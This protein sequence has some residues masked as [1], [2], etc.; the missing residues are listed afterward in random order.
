[1]APTDQIR[2]DRLGPAALTDAL[3]LSEEAGWNQTEADWRIFFEQ[4]VVFGVPGAAGPLA[5]GAVL[6]FGGFGWV[7]MVL[8]TGAAR[9]QGLGTA[10][11]KRCVAELSSMRCLSVL[12]A[13]PQGEQIYR[14]LGFL[15][16]FGLWRL[17]G[18][19]GGGEPVAG[20]RRAALA[21]LDTIVAL[22]ARAF[23][24]PR[25]RL[26]AGLLQRAPEAAVMLKDGSGF[27]L[28]RPGRR[29]LQIGPLVAADEAAALSLL[30]AALAQQSGPVIIDVPD[31]WAALGSHLEA[32]GFARERPFLRMALGRSEPFGDPGRLFA[33]AGPELG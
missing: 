24:A 8:V 11:L 29:A 19:G 1:M 18:E 26:L 16:Q 2:I 32:R 12:D 20:V 13:T 10:I 33:A 23:G 21:D 17:R 6:P 14:P 15:P 25:R 22:D 31:R 28:A 3:A 5:T 27:A 9:G 30:T 7:S 4:G